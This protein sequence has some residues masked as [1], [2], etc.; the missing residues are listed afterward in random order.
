MVYP[1]VL[2]A[3]GV[4]LLFYNLFRLISN[5]VTSGTKPSPWVLRTLGRCLLG[6]LVVLVSFFWIATL[7]VGIALGG[8]FVMVGGFAFDF[9]VLLILTMRHGFKIY[10]DG[11]HP[12]IWNNMLLVYGFVIGVIGLMITLAAN[13]IPLFF[14]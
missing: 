2:A 12:L 10:K 14:Q 8:I 7:Q 11:I 13:T 9:G 3:L 6:L 5:P 4:I 1:L